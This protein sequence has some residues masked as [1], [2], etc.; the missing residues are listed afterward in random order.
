MPSFPL[1]VPLLACSLGGAFAAAQTA[2]NVPALTLGQKFDHHAAGTAGIQA[3][4]GAGFGSALSQWSNTP[5]EWGQGFD[6]YSKRYASSFGS[7]LTRQALAFGLEGAL[8]E[9][10]RYFPSEDKRLSMRIKSVLLQTVM[11]RTDSG[12]RR[13]ATARVGSAFITGQIVN[14]WQPPSNDG[15]GNGV[16]RG[17]ITLSVDAASNLAQEFIPWLRPR[18]LRHHN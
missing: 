16:I 9:D 6:G 13:F 18:S 10:P 12:G 11:T 17:M 7:N 14:A 15:V 3:F 4:V 5:S 1:F 2:T 8:H